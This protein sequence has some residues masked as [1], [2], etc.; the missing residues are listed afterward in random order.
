MTHDKIL[1]LE[2]SATM[3]DSKD[4]PDL[5]TMMRRME[6]MEV[7]SGP[8][9]LFCQWGFT[10]TPGHVRTLNMTE[11]QGPTFKSKLSC[12]LSVLWFIHL[13]CLLSRVSEK[14]RCKVFSKLSD[15][16]PNK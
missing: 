9:G 12:Q 3:G 14:R 4:S 13:P 7:R 16:S 15:T 10:S 6:E 2:T 11:P 8:A 1:G 5:Q